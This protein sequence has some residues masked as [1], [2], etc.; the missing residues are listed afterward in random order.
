[1]SFEDEAAKLLLENHNIILHGAPGTG[2]TY[3]ARKIAEKLNC[4]ANE[5]GFV[6]FHQ[7]YDYSDFVEGLRPVQQDGQ[8]EVKFELKDGVFKKFC[9]NALNI[10]DESTTISLRLPVAQPPFIPN[11]D[12]NNLFDNIYQEIVNDIDRGII[13]QLG[14]KDAEIYVGRDNVRRINIAGKKPSPENLSLLFDYLIQHNWAHLADRGRL[15]WDTTIENLTNGATKQVDYVACREILKEMKNRLEQRDGVA[16]V[17]AP[18]HEAAETPEEIDENLTVKKPFVFIIDE[19]NRGEMSKIFGELFYSVDPG[20]RVK[21]EELVG[22]QKPFAIQTQY[23]NL[24][25]TPNKFDEKLGIET[26][27]VDNFGHFFVPENVYV[28]GTMNDI[29]RSVESMDFAMRRRFAFMEVLAAD[30]CDML[31]GLGDKKEDAECRMQ[32]LNSAIEEIE[33][34]SSAYDIGP[35]Y[36]LK[37]NKYGGDFNKLWKYH[38]EGVVKEYLRGMDESDNLLEKLRRAYYLIPMANGN[39]GD[40]Q[41]ND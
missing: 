25:K 14:H 22:G 37:L 20:Y 31:E 36:F 7:S 39:D 35:A 34:L 9:A 13:T 30:C 15:F 28:I 8:T 11:P 41:E 26:T 33:G 32:S 38:I 19:I 2:K 27:D 16:E 3:L 40:D 17:P 23:S 10:D 12:N 29:D 6:Q 18:D 5:I 1:M 4:S 24:Q 21:Y